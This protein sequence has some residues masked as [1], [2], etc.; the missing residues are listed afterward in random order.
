MANAP[1]PGYAAV[2]D[3]T[4]I[5]HRGAS[6]YAPEH[7]FASWDLALA[8]GADY[9]EQDLQL[10]RD[11]VLVVLHDDTLER[12]VRLAGQACH[13]PV[14]DWT[15]AE[16]QECDVGSWFN[17]RRPELARPEYAS[18]RLPTMADVLE[19]YE[20][21]ASFYIETKQPEAAPGMEEA[22]LALLRRHRLIEA[23]RREWRVLVQS[24]SEASLRKLQR[25]EPGLPLIQLVEEDEPGASLRGRLPVIAEYAVGIG[26]HYSQADEALIKAAHG[27]CLAVHPYT[28]NR[29]EDQASLAA[30]GVDGMFTDYPDRLL[31]T[32]PAAEPR[33]QSAGTAAAA[34]HRR[35]LELSA[36]GAPGD[37]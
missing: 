37:W 5:A 36:P 6:G 2:A 24:F 21:R 1:V 31:R 15:L 7:S 10:T 29:P 35:C 26:P 12:T 17:Q 27:R 8:L 22:L 4:V 13:G 34:A 30:A 25:L 32:R 9:L 3:L 23:A 11:G 14:S 20:G 19:R 28:V 18:Q 33:G 16:L